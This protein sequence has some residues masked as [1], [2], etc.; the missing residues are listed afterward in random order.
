MKKVVM[1]LMFLILISGVFAM[2]DPVVVKTDPGYK[3]KIYAWTA[4]GGPLLNLAEGVADVD[5]IFSATF[6]SLSV[7]EVRYQV[8]T[9]DLR[10]NKIH[11]TRFDG[12]GTDEALEIDC[13][14]G[15][16]C[17]M[18]VMVSEEVTV[19][20][21]EVVPVVNDEVV[22]VVN[23]EVVEDETKSFV[24]SGDSKNIFVYYLI[25]GVLTFIVLMVMYFR[26]RHFR[27]WMT[28]LNY[29]S[30]EGEL[31]RIENEI[32]R[33]DKLIDLINEK[34]ERKIRLALAKKKLDRE[35]KKLEKMVRK[36]MKK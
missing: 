4:G 17:V 11:D 15:I 9:I 28:R 29:L 1:S 31:A 12:F 25:G 22:S 16:D 5:G 24:A 20:D 10:D 21:S 32:K 19:N 36:K 23:D 6:F 27:D 7:S 26:F 8:M 34:K 14:V 3:V 13:T 33:K 35:N 30:E 2:E 18:S